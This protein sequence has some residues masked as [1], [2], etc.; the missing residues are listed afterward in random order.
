MLNHLGAYFNKIMSKFEKPNTYGSSLEYYITKN[1]PQDS[2]DVDRLTRK[3]E[4]MNLNRTLSGW[5]L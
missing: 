3:F 2:C 5:P 1:N 4:Q